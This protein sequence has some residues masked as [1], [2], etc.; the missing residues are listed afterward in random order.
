MAYKSVF[1]SGVFM[2]TYETGVYMVAECS[3]R[4]AQGP[5]VYQVY[6]NINTACY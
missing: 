4:F 3:I 5:N 6:I 1:V 2:L